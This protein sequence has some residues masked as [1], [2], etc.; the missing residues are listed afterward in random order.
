[1]AKS[2]SGLFSYNLREH[3]KQAN[4]DDGINRTIQKEP[5]KFWFYNNG[6]TIG[7]EDYMISGNTV[8][9]YNFSIINLKYCKLIHNFPS[10]LYHFKAKYTIHKYYKVQ[11]NNSAKPFYSLSF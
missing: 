4:V 9:L 6:I 8:K 5:D 1:M 3:I 10:L 2:K 7:C 11:Q